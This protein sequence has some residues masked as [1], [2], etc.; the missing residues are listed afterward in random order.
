MIFDRLRVTNDRLLIALDKL[1]E[2]QPAVKHRH[3]GIFGSRRTTVQVLIEPNSQQMHQQT[4]L[5]KRLLRFFPFYFCRWAQT[6][7]IRAILHNQ[8]LISDRRPFRVSRKHCIIDIVGGSAFIEDKTSQL[9]T[10]VNGILIGGNSQETRVKL[11]HG[12]NTL[13]L[14]GKDSQV[15][16]RLDVSMPSKAV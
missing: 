8:I 16:F 9:G 5:K 14:G 11:I 13:V 10:V 1:N 3:Q 12:L 6:T 7:S 4:A 2:L 15:R